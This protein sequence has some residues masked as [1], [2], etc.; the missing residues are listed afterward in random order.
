MIRGGRFMDNYPD[1]FSWA[2]YDD[3]FDPE[4]ECGCDAEDGCECEEE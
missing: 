4:L 1:G 2:E 3:Y